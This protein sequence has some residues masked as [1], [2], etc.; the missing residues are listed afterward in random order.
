MAKSKFK[1]K[2]HPKGFNE[3]RTSGD[4]QHTLD[5]MGEAIVEATGMPEDFATF[6]SPHRSRA[7]TIV[8]TSSQEGREAE[9]KDRTLTRAFGAARR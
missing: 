7:R 9:A 8:A 3:V 5:A 2:L 1:L 6:P 4:L